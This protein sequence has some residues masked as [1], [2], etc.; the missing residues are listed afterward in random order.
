[1]RNR[2]AGSATSG[3]RN[4]GGFG[5]RQWQEYSII[6]YMYLISE[7]TV[8]KMCRNSLKNLFYE[9]TLWVVHDKG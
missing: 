7:R 4:L 3:G 6:K 8:N 5:L 2:Q 1:M 9:K